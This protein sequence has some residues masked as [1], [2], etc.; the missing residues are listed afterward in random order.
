[1]AAAGSILL[2]TAPAQ[3]QPPVVSDDDRSPCTTGEGNSDDLTARDWAGDFIGLGEAHRF[4]Q[5]ANDDGV[6]V[7]IAVIDS[8]VSAERTDLFGS[9]VK[10][11]WDAWDAEGDGTCDAFYHGTAVAGIAAGAAQ[12]EQFVGVAPEADILPLRAFKGDEGADAN[13]A[14]MVAGLIEYAVDQGADVINVS[15]ALPDTTALKAAVDYAIASNVVVVAATGNENLYMDDPSVKA[16]PEKAKFYPANYPEVIAVGAHNRD[17]NFYLKTN[18]GENIDLIAPGDQVIVPLAGGGWMEDNGTSFATPYVA[19][20]AALLKAEFGDEASPAWIEHRLRTTALHPP[21]DFNIYQGYGVLNVGKAVSTPVSPGEDITA[22]SFDDEVTDGESPSVDVP[23]G[24][25]SSIAAIDV[26]YDPLA[27]EK[28]VA[29][30]SVGGALV[31][32]TL[33]LVLRTIIPKGRKRGW[34]PGS[35]RPEKAAPSQE[36]EGTA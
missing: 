11:G 17:G 34:R 30:A 4:N 7:T 18:Y 27:F 25:P 1:M 29:W 22:T 26:D 33:V 15:I 10:A 28:T 32:I 31:L 8:G 3:A 5:G 35:R 14:N 36:V 13:S 24:E 21:N 6:P 9:R 12:G 19:G 16:D 20:A 2:T 23:E